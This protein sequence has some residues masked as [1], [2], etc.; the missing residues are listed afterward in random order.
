[1]V[2][3]A[4]AIVGLLVIIG[5]LVGIKATQIS[6]LIKAGEAF[7]KAGPPPETVSSDVARELSWEGALVTVG[8]VS[9]ARGVAVSNDAPGVVKRIL[10]DSGNVA[11]SGQVLVELDTGVERAQVGTA[12]ARKELAEQNIKRQRSLYAS[13]GISKSQL[14]ND[15]STLKMAIAELAGLQ[16]QIE[17]K[18]VR[19]AF[20]G[21][22][23]IRAINLGQYLSPGTTVTTLEALDT[24]YV[25]FLL[26]QQTLGQVNIGAIVHIRIEGS[27]S[28][29][30]QGTIAA[31]DPRLDSGTRSLVIRAA[32]P[33]PEQ[34]LRPGMFANVGVMLPGKTSVVAVPSTAVVHAAYGDSIFLIE[35]ESTPGT[36]SES[37]KGANG[38]VKQVRQQFVKLGEERGDFVAVLDG[39]KPGQELVSAGAFK[40]RNGAKIVINNASKPNPQVAPRPENR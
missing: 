32:V 20:G 9:A 33:N 16:A 7:A 23:G 38:N 26:P 34:K 28:V 12:Q 22:L 8:T 40:L 31:I 17:R 29:E 35:G 19:A 24:V 37:A 6:G 39:V 36:K 4:V 25:D 21:R 30:A 13:G 10:F 11:K 5:G 3:Y 27:Q 14:D 15:E 18:I 1:M 2:R